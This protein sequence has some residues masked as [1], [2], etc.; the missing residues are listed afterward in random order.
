MCETVL[1]HFEA[2]HVMRYI[3][4]G[5]SYWNPKTGEEVFYDPDYDEPPLCT[6]RGV[7]NTFCLSLLGGEEGMTYEQRVDSGWVDDDIDR[8]EAALRIVMEDGWEEVDG[9]VHW[10]LPNDGTEGR[11]ARGRACITAGA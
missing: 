9:W 3:R 5:K 4:D 2:L 8:Y 7:R 6:D 10:S 1:Q 11:P